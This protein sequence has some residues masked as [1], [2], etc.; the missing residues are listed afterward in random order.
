MAGTIEAS[1]AISSGQIDLWFARCDAAEGREDRYRSLLTDDEREHEQRFLVARHSHRYLVTR[2][3]IRTVLSRY[4]ATP[5]A[6]WRFAT[7]PY[8]RPEIANDTEVHGGLSFN[9]SHTSEMI[10]MG[11]TRGNALGVDIETVSR[12]RAPLE[13]AERFF[14]TDEAA[15]LSALPVPLQRDRFVQLWTLKEAYMKACGMGFSIAL[16]SFRFDLSD[17]TSIGFSFVMPTSDASPAWRFWQLRPFPDHAVAVCAGKRFGAPP[18]LRVLKTI[19][20]DCDE[21][22]PWTLLRQSAD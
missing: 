9:V 8:G 19:P 14:S 11:V 6:A 13:I 7:N 22:H 1:R 17:D 12:V 15:A 16:D 2:A 18:R 3:L 4:C 21:V 20:L 5:P 10:L